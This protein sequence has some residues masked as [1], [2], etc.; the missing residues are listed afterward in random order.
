MIF[1]ELAQSQVFLV[2]GENEVVHAVVLAVLVSK[3]R[4]FENAL[5]GSLHESHM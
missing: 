4:A 1:S 5:C 3:L 2:I